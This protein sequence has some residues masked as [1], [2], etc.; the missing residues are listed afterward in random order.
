MV[1]PAFFLLSQIPIWPVL[2]I[3]A[4]FFIN[5][6]CQNLWNVWFHPLAKVPGPRLAAF[7]YWY[8]TYVEVVKGESWIEHLKE[9]HSRYGKIGDGRGRKDFADWK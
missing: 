6:F 2:G 7:W 1:N 3:V 9:L 5:S 4:Y 8:K